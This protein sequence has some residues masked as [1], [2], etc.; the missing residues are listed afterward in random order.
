M[1]KKKNLEN[2]IFSVAIVASLL[3]CANA[4]FG[5]DVPKSNAS[6]ADSATE[7][8]F[9]LLQIQAD[10]QGNLTDLDMDVA[11]AAQ[12][13]STTGLEG[14]AAR[15]VLRKLL[16]TNSNLAQAAIFS[17]EGKIIIAEDKESKSAEGADISSQE[18][19]AHVLKTKNPTF[20]KQFLLVEGYNGTSLDYPVFSPQGEFIGG[21]SAI[22]EPDKLMNTL[23]APQLHFNTSTRSNITDYSFWSM[24]KDGLI[25]YDRDESQIG[26]YLFEDPLYKPYPSLIDLGKRIVAEKAGHGNY[27]FQ[28]TEENERVVTKDTY[29]TTAGLH[30]TEWRLVVTMIM[31]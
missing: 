26:K 28:V 3:F 29:W 14:T 1:N 10:V 4:A 8:P 7:M 15:E 27:S 13:L 31:Q 20:S 16:E 2:S 24:H 17:K 22:I 6:T 25:A 12:N 11:E 18:H 19:I 30:G 23:V 9:M 5:Q 21:I